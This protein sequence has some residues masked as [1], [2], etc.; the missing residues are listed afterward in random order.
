MKCSKKQRRGESQNRQA[1]GQEHETKEIAK[2][3]QRGDCAIEDVGLSVWGC[4]WGSMWFRQNHFSTQFATLGR[5]SNHHLPK[6]P[7]RSLLDATR[8]ISPI[9]RLV[10]LL[11]RKEVSLIPMRSNKS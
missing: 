2:K 11:N 6:I 7:T 4:G 1:S 3:A 10:R 5:Q 8:Q 9:E